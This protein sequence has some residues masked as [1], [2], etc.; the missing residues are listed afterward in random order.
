MTHISY[1]QSGVEARFNDA[2]LDDIIIELDDASYAKAEQVLF[3]PDSRA[4]HAVM[5]EGV[6]FI[7]T[8]PSH[9]VDRISQKR[10]VIL[11]AQH[12]SGAVL[13][14]KADVVITH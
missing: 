5:H 13:R 10:E 1:E 4:L 2:D 6:F 7:G 14:L 11:N 12:F 8:V 3:N 9:C